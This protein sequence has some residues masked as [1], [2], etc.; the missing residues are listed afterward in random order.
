MSGHER[1]LDSR[2]VALALPELRADTA[3]TIE[4]RVGRVHRSKDKP[5][6]TQAQFEAIQKAAR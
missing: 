2:V 5:F 3:R 1:L 6:Y 4:M